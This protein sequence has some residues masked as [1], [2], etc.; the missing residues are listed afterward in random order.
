MDE[1][2]ANSEKNA[3]I[4][5]SE[6]TQPAEADEENAAEMESPQADLEAAAAADTEAEATQA[7]AQEGASVDAPAADADAEE[8]AALAAISAALSAELGAEEAVNAVAQENPGAEAGPLLSRAEMREL[9]SYFL[10][11]PGIREQVER[12]LADAAGYKSNAITSLRGN[13]IIQGEEGSGKTVFATSLI[14][15]LQKVV[16]N[17]EAKIGKISAASLN[18]KD[19]AALVP[20]IA[21]GYLIIEKAGELTA[22]TAVRMSQ[23]M[24]RNTQGMVVILEDDSAGINRVMG[25]DFSFAKKFTGKVKIPIFTIDE[26]VAFGKSYAQEMECVIEEMGVL[27]MYNRINNIQKLDRATTLAEVKDIVDQAIE[28]AESGGLKK[29]FTKKYNENDYLI[30]R[31]KDFE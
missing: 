2:A 9:F 4:E 21:G 26:L 28:R 1:T 10:P 3:E 7:S 24:E 19:F 8:E 31:E 16:G 5:D 6:D 12:I 27:A 13:L 17:E 30:L 15:A 14:R 23:I 25:L 11:V 29:L 22:A 20:K 18:R